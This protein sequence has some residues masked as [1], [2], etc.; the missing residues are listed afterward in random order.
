MFIPERIP[1]QAAMILGVLS[2][3]ITLSSAQSSKCYRGDDIQM[4]DPGEI[5]RVSYRKYKTF[6]L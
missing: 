3:L 6:F 4:D 1:K 5:A 2:Q